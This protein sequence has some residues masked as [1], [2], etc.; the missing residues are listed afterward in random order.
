[1]RAGYQGA[2]A[3]HS[4][5]AIQEFVK[6]QSSPSCPAHP[7]FP[8]SLTAD[9]VE[10]VGF[11]STADLLDAVV[12]GSAKVGFLP[13][14]NSQSGSFT[15]LYDLLL[16][17]YCGRVFIV[18]EFA[19]HDSNAL[20]C[21]PQGPVTTEADIECIYSHPH[22]LEQCSNEVKRIRNM[23][24]EKGLSVLRTEDTASAAQYLVGN[25]NSAAAIIASPAAAKEY[26]LRIL[27]D[28]VDNDVRSVTRYIIV[29]GKPLSQEQLL[30]SAQ[31]V[32]NKCSVAVSLQNSPGVLFKALSCFAMRDINV[33]KLESRPAVSVSASPWE[34]VNYI[35]FDIGSQ[36]QRLQ[37]V[38]DNLKEFAVDVK[39]LGTYPRFSASPA[40]VSASY[41]V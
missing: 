30:V 7:L 29:A 27:K 23:R 17:K 39:L 22:V 25:Q 41:G 6:M 9:Q 33:T 12:S 8:R 2:K 36:L 3:S 21:L 10:T 1:M 34:Y 13:A 31:M 38:L 4:Q 5:L 24:H 37:L 15:Q 19:V 28:Q 16:Q 20:L 35:D 40:Q 26:G 18:G 11:P 14:E 32:S